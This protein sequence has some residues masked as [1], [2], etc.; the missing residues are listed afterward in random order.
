MSRARAVLRIS[1]SV[2]DLDL[3][4]ERIRS[5]CE[6]LGWR[7]DDE[8]PGSFPTGLPCIELEFSKPREGNQDTHDG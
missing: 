2:E 6:G 5:I 1:L 8:R 4:K 7:L 3:A